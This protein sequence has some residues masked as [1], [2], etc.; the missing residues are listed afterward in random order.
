MHQA[1][2]SMATRHVG[3]PART[4]SAG[5]VVL[6]AVTDTGAN[7]SA[8]GASVRGT[9][10]HRHD[11]SVTDVRVWVGHT[12]TGQHTTDARLNDTGGVLSASVG[13]ILG[14]T[15]GSCGSGR[16]GHLVHTEKK[17]PFHRRWKVLSSV[18]EQRTRSVRCLKSSGP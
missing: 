18:I 6:R 12:R 3:G 1:D 5:H 4:K 9:G 7:A 14:A 17:V 11:G 16:V 15:A 10:E 13:C 8:C 2:C